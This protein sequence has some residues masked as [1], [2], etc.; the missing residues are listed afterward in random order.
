MAEPSYH[1]W[2][3]LAWRGWDGACCALVM[4]HPPLRHHREPFADVNVSLVQLSLSLLYLRLSLFSSKH[5]M[6]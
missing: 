4:G 6:C 3:D 1:P 5:K 2:A